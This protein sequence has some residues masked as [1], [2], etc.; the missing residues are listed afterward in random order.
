MLETIR[1][2]GL[3]A[4]TSSGEGN[5]ARL[6]HA[7]YF[8]Q[9]A[10]EAEP[11]LKGP[12]LATWLD[13]LEREH[14]NLRAALHWAIEGGQAEMALRLGSAL[15]RFW[16]V[17][18]HRNEGLAFLERAL[19]GSA[20]VAADVRAKASL[21]AARLAF[22][23]SN[24]D[25]GEMLAQQSLALF[26]ELGDRRGIALSLNRLGV[27]AWRRG[28]FR[29]ARI[30]LEEDLTL[31]RELGDRDRV[32]WSL[33][34]HGLLDNKQGEYAGA[35][36]QFE[37]SLA[38]FRELGNK[39][40]IAASLTQLAGTLFVSQGNQDMI[41]PL[42][43]QGLSLDREVGD[44]E[45]MAVASL[46]LGWVALKQGDIATARTRVEESLAL[47][48]EMEHREGMA[49]A[50]SLLARLEATRDDHAFAHV[51]YEESLAIAQEIGDKE[52]IASGLGGLASVVAAQ[53]EPGWAARLW[54]SAEVMR[55]AIGAP[56]PPIE[57]ADYDHAVAAVREHLGEEAFASAWAEG[58][59]M[60]VEQV[61]AAGE[62][63]IQL[64]QSQE[65]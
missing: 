35:S 29:S 57:R 27:A 33:F 49:E 14:D 28:D 56:L 45:G 12:L 5:S 47:Y 20:G 44:K 17:R 61:L 34:M 53:D 9:L 13:R 2:Y 43:E 7:D 50:L 19:A 26:R 18:G 37:E 32:A 23:Q 51:L 41:Y 65:V 31:F 58:R 46:L 21:A 42:L 48:K 36:S 4:L 1:E 11:A 25:Q 55:E 52:L 40:G 8:L 15:E 54:G 22:N 38:L 3:E 10:E 64:H 59:A 30:L 6:A 16:V 63:T 62:R 39:R 24:Y 60:T